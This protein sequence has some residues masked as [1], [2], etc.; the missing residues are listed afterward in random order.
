MGLVFE[1]LT[2]TGEERRNFGPSDPLT[3]EVQNDPGMTEFREEWAASGYQVPF[4]WEHTIDEREEG[5][6]VSRIIRGVGVFIREHV[7]H[8]GLS[9]FG[10]GSK[11]PS[12]QIDAVGG[13]IG[14]LAKISVSPA[15]NGKGVIHTALWYK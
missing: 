8:L 3:V 10:L 7:V 15:G 14:S 4:S 12:G 9:A 2:Q 5:S 13:T 6:P 11:D 1:W